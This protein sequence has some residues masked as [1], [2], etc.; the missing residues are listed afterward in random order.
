MPNTFTF[1]EEQHEYRNAAGRVVLSVTQVLQGSGLVD[2][3]GID[4]DVLARKAEIGTA[5]HAAAHYLDEGDLDW[6]TVAPE[7]V[8]YVKAWERCKAETGLECTL[9]ERQGI[10]VL[11]GMEYGYKLDRSVYFSSAEWLGELKC[12]ANEEISWG[13]QTAAYELAARYLDGK[14]RKR[15]VFH[16]RKNGTYRL[17]PLNDAKDYQV[18]S[19][20][21]FLEHWKQ[22]KRSK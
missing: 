12:T 21:L 19:M 17:I 11:N 7:V 15:V 20:A 8:G 14:V 9:I 13:P 4:E 1:S 5:A 18:F 2:Y 10:H 6:S 22:L 3:S 16:L